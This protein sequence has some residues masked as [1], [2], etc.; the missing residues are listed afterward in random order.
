MTPEI[1]EIQNRIKK[2][3][4]EALKNKRVI[5][6]KAPT[7]SGKTIMMSNI[8]NDIIAENPNVIFIVSSLSKSELAIQ[9]YQKFKE[10][11][12][13]EN[14]YLKPNLITS[15][16][17]GE[18]G[19]HID[20]GYNVYVLARDLF[21]EKSR[22]AQGALHNFIDIVKHGVNSKEIYLIKDE[23]H[24]ATTNL[25]TLDYY[26]SKIINV[27]ATP[28]PKRG[29][30]PDV[31]LTEA[32]AVSNNMIKK[33]DYRTYE[34]YEDLEDKL[35]E[36]LSEFVKSKKEYNEKLNINPCFIIQISTKE[37]AEEEVLKI[38]RVLQKHFDTLKWMLIVNDAKN[39][40][41]NDILNK[42]KDKKK[43]KEY[44]KNANATIDIIIFKM[45]ITEGW[46][47]PRA[48]MLFQVRDSK[49]KQ[50]DEQVIGRVRRNP[51]IQNFETLTDE[52]RRIISTATVWGIYGKDTIKSVKVSVVKN[53]TPKV[54]HEFKLKTTLLNFDA[55]NKDF[56]IRKLLE[57][58]NLLDQTN[59]HEQNISI[60]DLYKIYDSANF[61]V[62][63]IIDKQVK[64][65]EDWIVFVK[66]IDVIA[67]KLKQVSCDYDKYLEIA[68][69]DLGLELET[70]LPEESS[71]YLTE[72]TKEIDDWIWDTEDKNISK[73]SFDSDAER[74]WAIIL[75]KLAKSEKK[76]VKTVHVSSYIDSNRFLIGKN[77]LENSQIRYGYYN[78][79]SKFSYP[80]FVLKDCNNHFH[81]FEVKSLNISSSIQIDEKEYVEK[82]NSLKEGYQANSKKL[83]SYY[84]YI[85]IKENSYWKIYRYHNGQ[86]QIFDKETFFKNFALNDIV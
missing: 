55:I 49:S 56:S 20:L 2:E 84:F 51:M 77:F 42:N 54:E 41:T 76:L 58:N 29:Q 48:N 36:A 45:M 30:V 67:K 12:K 68:K 26:F 40:E 32:E 21:K 74:E 17:S 65:Y 14:T 19:L 33:V 52:Q 73:F 81:I 28:N 4:I 10:R 72:H 38:K 22:L 70:S 60:F 71:F 23:C 15:D 46:D 47:I 6:L 66:N 9:N 3:T 11:S 37:K 13:K 82:I 75:S 1:I 53:A 78:Y 35:E 64:S 5:T 7:G 69:D 8:M 44:A 80:D 57:E 59:I 83:P 43:W 85:P 34:L 39:C 31:E 50:L 25:D 63:E 79:G 61:N 16:R 24:Q 27:S 18:E 86:E 62:K